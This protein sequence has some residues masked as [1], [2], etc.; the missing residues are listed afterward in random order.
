M[1]YDSPMKGQIPAIVS[2]LPF[3][4]PILTIV[5]A[6]PLVMQKV[7]PNWWYGFRTRKTLSDP[8][9]W[10]RANYLGGVGLLYAGIISLAINLSLSI[11][12]DSPFVLPL[13]TGVVVVSMMVALIVWSAQMQ[14]L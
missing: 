10:Y 3:A 7:P 14:S 9:I 6:L 12:M 13:Q 11:A 5:T 2:Y 4:L 1:D 8:Q